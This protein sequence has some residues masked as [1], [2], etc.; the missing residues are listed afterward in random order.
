MASS[1]SFLSRRPSTQYEVEA[2]SGMLVSERRECRDVAGNLVRTYGKAQL[3]T[4]ELRQFNRCWSDTVEV[5]I[6][7]GVRAN[8]MLRLLD[9]EESKPR[10]TVIF[11]MG[12]TQPE[13]DSQRNWVGWWKVASALHDL[14]GVNALGV[15][16]D[17]AST[18]E[19]DP[20]SL[21]EVTYR[22][23]AEV[24]IRAIEECKIKPESLMVVAWGLACEIFFHI[25]A[26]RSKLLGTQHVFMDPVVE[27]KLSHGGVMTILKN[28]PHLSVLV[29]QTYSY[30]N[31]RAIMG[32]GGAGLHAARE[33]LSA[34]DQS[35]LC[36]GPDQ[37][38]TFEEDEVVFPD[39]TLASDRGKDAFVQLP[40]YAVCAVAKF[41]SR[42][43][44]EE[45]F[46]SMELPVDR[47]R[48]V[49]WA[50]QKLE[51]MLS[52][53]SVRAPRPAGNLGDWR[54]P[55]PCLRNCSS[56]ELR[57]DLFRHKPESEFVRKIRE[58][59]AE[60][61]RKAQHV[62]RIAFLEEDGE[63]PEEGVEEVDESGAKRELGAVSE[64]KAEKPCHFINQIY[65]IRCS[66][67]RE[68][69]S[70]F[71]S[72]HRGA[73]KKDPDGC[74]F[75][76]LRRQGYCPFPREGDSEFCTVHRPGCPDRSQG[77]RWTIAGATEQV[78]R[79]TPAVVP[80]G[81]F[82]GRQNG[83]LSSE[84]GAFRVVLAR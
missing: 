64:K 50:D 36:Q 31:L 58:L 25:A 9:E 76:V 7:D 57:E 6:K 69:R 20:I 77:R 2:S 18:R 60:D 29:L 38:H 68:S 15:E 39:V 23:Q 52:R 67:P 65:G 43:L 82:R 8:V 48:L 56:A 79:S 51:S 28:S 54:P 45:R 35:G 30:S 33:I 19:A 41:L 40:Q 55:R 26:M 59:E 47:D 22:Q 84:G 72:I 74:A 63:G 1:T 13:K 21:Q 10:P 75:W 27:G 61:A 46:P 80:V 44:G 32:V 16:I 49:T 34:M 71:C 37:W 5:E 83:G 81:V 3:T 62:N 17:W 66:F 73:G 70:R 78:C 42:E 11:V 24:F 53:A 12:P 4:R 14:A